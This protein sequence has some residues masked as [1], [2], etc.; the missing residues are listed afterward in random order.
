MW[1][2][3]LRVVAVAITVI[4]AVLALAGCGNSEVAISPSVSPSD[5]QSQTP[6]DPVVEFLAANQAC[7]KANSQLRDAIN[8][9]IAVATTDPAAM[10][11]PTLIDALNQAIA[12]AQTTPECVVPIMADDTPTI[13]QQTLELTS[14]TR[15]VV[16]AVSAL[17]QASQSVTG[18]VIPESSA[19]V[20][21]SSSTK[22]ATHTLSVT[23]NTNDGY[24]YTTTVQLTDWVKAADTS[25][26]TTEWQSMGGTGSWTLP[27]DPNGVIFG[28]YGQGL[29]YFTAEKSA[30]FFGKVTVTNT[31]PGGFTL[32]KFSTPPFMS[33][34][35]GSSVFAICTQ[36]T[37]VL[38]CD[39]Y[40]WGN[41][42]HTPTWEV[43]AGQS[44]TQ[45]F[46]IVDGTA[47]IPTDPTGQA[48]VSQTISL[49]MTSDSPRTTLSKTW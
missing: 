21:P 45:T 40:G 23:T 48:T 18:S 9:A 35:P 1:N 7:D 3:H 16:S 41:M 37:T 43:A 44:I 10:K 13:E 12:A 26:A 19:D 2:S 5:T 29:G 8:N 36:F 25:R 27:V 39:K 4:V 15:I 33:L 17:T 14:S 46:F 42:S 38:A 31:T 28:A 22:A 6:P 30:V 20:K 24:S 47:F 49:G 34:S 32:P 11:D